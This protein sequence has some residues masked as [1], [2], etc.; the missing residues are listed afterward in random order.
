MCVKNFNQYSSI[1]YKNF[2]LKRPYAKTLKF[3]TVVCIFNEQQRP[4]APTKIKCS[5]KSLSP[6]FVISLH[7]T[8]TCPVID[9]LRLTLNPIYSY[10]SWYSLSAYYE[11]AISKFTI[12]LFAT[13]S[14]LH[15]SWTNSA[16][17]CAKFVAITSAHFPENKISKLVYAR[18]YC[19]HWDESLHWCESCNISKVNEPFLFTSI[20]MWLIRGFRWP[21]WNPSCSPMQSTN[22][23]SGPYLL[24]LC[25][26]RVKSTILSYMTHKKQQVNNNSIFSKNVL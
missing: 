26:R 15:L 3:H 7:Q 25:K 10:H 22:K 6:P 11:S 14:I 13:P 18:H 12:L 16:S 20:S 21:A 17:E 5:R 8:K 19:L 4:F 9:I 2:K 1:Q 23:Q 24:I